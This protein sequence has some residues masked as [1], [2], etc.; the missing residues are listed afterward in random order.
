M[1]TRT[2]STSLVFTGLVIT[3]SAFWLFTRFGG[4][5]ILFEKL[6]YLILIGFAGLGFVYGGYWHLTRPFDKQQYPRIIAWINFSA[7]FLSSLGV[8]AS[9]LNSRQ[10]T[11]EDLGNVIHL[12]GSIGL[13]AGLLVGT[14]HGRAISNAEAAARAKERAEALE[15]EQER[16][17]EL[18]GLL[19]HYILN[20]VQ[21]IEGYASRLQ[22]VVPES[23]QEAVH[24]ILMRTDRMATLIENIS[25]I[26]RFQRTDGSLINLDSAIQTATSKVQ[27]QTEATVVTPA[28]FPSVEVNEDLVDALA[29]LCEAILPNIEAGG[30]L[31]IK[32]GQPGQDVTILLTAKPAHLPPG[33][34]SS[35]F[36]P[37]A[38][39]NGL[40]FYL[41]E[42]LLDDTGELKLADST[43]ETLQFNLKLDILSDK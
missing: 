13:L 38:S 24:T 29:L 40:K 41:A 2:W 27:P 43:E 11:P 16:L 1:R 18:N 35:L 6:I 7:V 26:T 39:D 32:C 10:A 12:T 17:D 36:E 42:Q 15:D 20:G 28:E 34:A 33:I 23:D 31:S 30:K 14:I 4:G 22:A 21:V 8:I 5:V 9:Y 3:G 19:R 25:S 37:I